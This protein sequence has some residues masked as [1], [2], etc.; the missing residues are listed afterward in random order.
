MGVVFA[1]SRD[2]IPTCTPRFLG[3]RSHSRSN[4]FSRSTCKPLSFHYPKKLPH[5]YQKLEPDKLL[6]MGQ[7]K[8]THR[9]NKFHHIYVGTWAK[10]RKCLFTQEFAQKNLHCQNSYNFVVCHNNLQ[11][12]MY[13][14]QHGA[15]NIGMQAYIHE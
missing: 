13:V 6:Q 8:W 15:S 7:I 14:L 12:F 1:K 4:I 9:D 5:F 11:T 2:Q 10:R 3:R